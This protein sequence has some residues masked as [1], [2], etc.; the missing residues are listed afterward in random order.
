MTI[1]YT[2]NN[3]DH[4]SV[5]VNQDDISFSTLG[6]VVKDM[7]HNDSGVI[8]KYNNLLTDEIKRR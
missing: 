3:F 7:Y 2:N 8:N 4:Y 5:Y 6:W 1:E